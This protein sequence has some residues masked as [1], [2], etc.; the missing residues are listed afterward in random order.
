[1]TEQ[2]ER[3]P[4]ISPDLTQGPFVVK[5]A[6]QKVEGQ[7]QTMGRFILGGGENAREQ[8]IQSMREINDLPD[9]LSWQEL[10]TR[11]SG[12]FSTNGLIRV[13]F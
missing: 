8:L 12:I 1:M 13:D 6:T 10:R 5:L 4:K 7:P 11:A 3:K 2:G 9:G